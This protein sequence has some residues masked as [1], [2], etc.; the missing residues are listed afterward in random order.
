MAGQKPTWESHLAS[1]L[2]DVLPKLQLTHERRLTVKSQE[3]L[4]DK[5]ESISSFV[6]K[7]VK[8]KLDVAVGSF[9]LFVFVS[10]EIEKLLERQKTAGNGENFIKLDTI[11]SR[12][13]LEDIIK[14]C[15]QLIKQIP[16]SY[17][18]LLPFPNT[19]NLDFDPTNQICVDDRVSFG[20]LESFEPYSRILQIEEE[21]RQA[22][23]SKLE[24]V[25]AGIG[26]LPKPNE[27]IFFLSVKI[28]G[29]IGR[30]AYDAYPLE[31]AGTRCGVPA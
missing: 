4:L 27:D 9:P 23:N 22:A 19:S 20:F 8:E 12:N 31:S 21:K 1:A 11:A 26:T 16:K 15:I 29:Y 14:N 13:D 5:S 2:L 24:R 6:P 10:E 17:T 3:F 28:D 18:F 30:F 25:F 7:P